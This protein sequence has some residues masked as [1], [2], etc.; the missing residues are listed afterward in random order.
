MPSMTT[1]NPEYRP[2]D[3]IL[4]RYMPDASEAEREEARA[5]LYAFVAVLA[6]I[7]RRRTDEQI[8]AEIR[9]KAKREVESEAGNIP[10]I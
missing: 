1:S 4:N 5:N 2:G 10:A 9:A 3:I 6:R 7:A 8:E